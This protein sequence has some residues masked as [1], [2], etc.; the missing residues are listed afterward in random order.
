MGPLAIAGLGAGG[1]GAL[2]I[3]SSLL[4]QGNRGPS[5][6]FLETNF[7]PGQLAM[8]TETLY[9]LLTAS[10]A[11]SQQLQQ[12]NLAG[13]QFGNRLQ[14]G[15]GARGLQSSG[16]GT[17]ASSLAPAVTS[18]L[19]QQAF[20]GVHEQAFQ[21]A[22]RNLMARMGAFSQNYQTG[23]TAGDIFQNLFGSG[24]MGLGQILALRSLGSQGQPQQPQQ[25][26]KG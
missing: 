13:S 26:Q 6:G 20:A 15:L 22:L 16:V 11:F 3:L 2:G 24:I 1:T 23:P 25:Q 10:P 12:A 17:V 5:P 14:A 7:G 8:D 19:R 18:Q 21:S 9:K 4:A